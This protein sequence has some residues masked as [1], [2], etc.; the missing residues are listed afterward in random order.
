MDAYH[1]YESNVI[2]RSLL[3]VHVGIF[4]YV[5][6][7]ISHLR[8]PIMFKT[9]IEI[10]CAVVLQFCGYYHRIRTSFCMNALRSRSRCCRLFSIKQQKVVVAAIIT[11]ATDKMIIRAEKFVCMSAKID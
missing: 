1:I 10:Y 5:E 3:T 4:N 7:K 8:P 2:L 9:I 6:T 11:P